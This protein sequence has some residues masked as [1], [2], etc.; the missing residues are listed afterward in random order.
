MQKFKLHSA[1][2]RRSQRKCVYA[3]LKLIKNLFALLVLISI[4]L[5]IIPADT[6]ENFSKLITK[7]ENYFDFRVE[8]IDVSG[9]EKI[10]TSE[11]LKLA[12]IKKGESLINIDLEKVSQSI[13]VNKWV[14]S[15]V[16]SRSFPNK[17]KILIE[18]EK[19][20]AVYLEKDKY[21]L[22][23]LSG[24]K[25]ESISLEVAQSGY[26]I[27][28]GDGANS[29][30]SEVLAEIYNH[31]IIN[32]SVIELHYKAQRRW[33]VVLDNKTKIMLP[34]RNF[35]EGIKFANDFLQESKIKF[36]TVI[37]LRLL[38]DK[39]YLREIK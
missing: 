32:K 22:V 23:N 24:K 5:F 25:I 2:Q 3:F 4:G 16:V 12:S 13:H 6:P 10:P 39:I 34:E 15:L 37:D 35:A 38:P 30:F 11:I 7:F 18:E 17:I 21:F 20:A 33:D 29:N 1:A 8:H 28:K 14:S 36:A 9:N 19:P 31:H 27:L 26:I